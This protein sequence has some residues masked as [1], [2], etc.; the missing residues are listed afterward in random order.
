VR[1]FKKLLLIFLCWRLLLFLPLL[2]LSYLPKVQGNGYVFLDYYE[3]LRFPLNNIFLSAWANFDGVHYLS[4]AANGYTTDARFLPLLPVLIKMISLFIPFRL[5]LTLAY[6]IAF[7]LSNGLFF[8]SL[9][10]LYKLLRFDYSHTVVKR[11]I[12]FL[13]VFPASFFFGS[14]YAESLFLFVSVLNLYLLRQKKFLFAGLLGAL[15]PLIRPVGIIIFPTFLAELF[16]AETKKNPIPLWKKIILSTVTLTGFIGY[17]VFNKMKWN[18]YFYFIHAQGQLANG[19]ATNT[20]ILF[21]HTLYRYFKIFA[22]IPVSDHLWHVALLEVFAFFFGLVLLYVC[23]R[24]RIRLSYLVF[25]FF[26]FFIPVSSG[27]FTGLP[28]YLIV[29]FPLFLA[30]A[31]IRNNGIKIIYVIISIILSAILLMLFAG[32]YYIA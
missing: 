3:K 8:F 28:R 29:L 20:I 26:G 4:I 24:K 25:A 9:I 2:F 27:T 30:I 21:P 5:T 32:G 13:M 17:A 15:L 18:D 22:T 1:Y 6:F 12:L 7:I 10:L 16:I 23:Y 11:V 14:V 31:L 19:R